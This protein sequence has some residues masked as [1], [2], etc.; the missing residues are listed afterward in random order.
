MRMRT[1]VSIVTVVGAGALLLCALAGIIAFRAQVANASI[2][3]P[4]PDSHGSYVEVSL[5]NTD[6]APGEYLHVG[7][8]FHGLPCVPK[9]D[10]DNND[11][12]LCNYKDD[13]APGLV[14]KYEVL[15]S[16]GA[17]SS[18]CT[19]SGLVKIGSNGNVVKDINGNYEPRERMLS[20]IYSHWKTY[21]PASHRIPPSLRA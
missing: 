20:G 17:P 18:N 1:K 19:P 8:L 5:V 10:L 21:G 9:R 4:H 11:L 15:D 14:Y 13:F 6:V 2:N 3:P 12:D 7:T 16:N